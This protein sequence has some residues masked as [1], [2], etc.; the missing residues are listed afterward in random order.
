MVSGTLPPKSDNSIWALP[1][2]SL[3]L[4]RQKP[5]EWTYSPTSSGVA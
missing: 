2:M 4:A 1:T 5:Q 3:A